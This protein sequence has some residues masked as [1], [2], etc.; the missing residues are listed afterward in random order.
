MNKILYDRNI[1]SLIRVLIGQVA[2]QV[3]KPQQ[4]SSITFRILQ[5]KITNMAKPIDDPLKL[6]ALRPVN[7]RM[8]YG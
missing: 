5:A 4:S 8:A 3:R 2:I 6:E 1:Q 7:R